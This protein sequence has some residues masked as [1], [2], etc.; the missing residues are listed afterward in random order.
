MKAPDRIDAAQQAFVQVMTHPATWAPFAPIAAAYA[1]IGLP[2]WLCLVLVMVLAAVVFAAWKGRWPRL[3]ETAHTR[4]LMKYRQ[5]ETAAL[6]ERLA[7]VGN[8]LAHLP[9]R[10]LLYELRE[11]MEIKYAV[12]A[13]VFGDGVITPHEEEVNEMFAG[14]VRTMMDEAERASLTESGQWPKAAARFEKAM[15]SLRA[16]FEQIDVILDPV[17]EGLRMPTETDALSRASERLN[18]RLEQARGVRRHLEQAMPLDLEP[19][20]EPDATSSSPLRQPT[21]ER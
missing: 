5:T 11:A 19:S 17:P 21:A 20:S 14:M 18:E 2:W 1:F 3:M 10:R 9:T 15:D 13:R 4:L 12:E 16:A 7:R 6:Y 8:A